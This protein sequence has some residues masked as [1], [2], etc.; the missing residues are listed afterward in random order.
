MIVDGRVTELL[1]LAFLLEHSGVFAGSR[2]I[3]A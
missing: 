3:A 1:D 2:G